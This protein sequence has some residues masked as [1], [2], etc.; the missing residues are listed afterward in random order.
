MAVTPS[1]KPPQNKRN[2]TG[3]LVALVV[4]AA[5]GISAGYVAQLPDPAPHT[6]E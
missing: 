2:N 1:K 3:C 6:A 4:T 5:L